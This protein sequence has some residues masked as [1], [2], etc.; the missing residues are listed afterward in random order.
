MIIINPGTEPLPE[1][2]EENAGKAIDLFVADL[3]ERGVH[4]VKVWRK[5]GNDRG[6]GWFAYRILTDTDRG[7][8]IGMPGI[9]PEATHAGVPFTSPRLYVDGSSW[10]WGY[11][12]NMC[13]P[14]VIEGSDDE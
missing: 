9:D 5:P 6:G 14:E 8:N 13:T 11:A 12:L 7:Y 10:L 3:N 1:A 4:V 2:T